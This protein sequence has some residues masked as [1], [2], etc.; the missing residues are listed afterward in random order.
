MKLIASDL[1]GTLLNEKGEISEDNLQAIKKIEGKGIQFVVATGR[2]YDA[3]NKPFQS[4]GLSCPFI[5]LNGANTFDVN[6]Q[7]IHEVTMEFPVCQK[8]IS[9][10]QKAD[11]Y[12]EVFTNYGIYSLSRE[13]FMEVI[14]HVLQTAHADSK[15]EDIQQLIEQRFQDENVQFIN[16]FEELLSSQDIKVYKILSF[17]NQQGELNEAYEKLKDEP[18][19]VITSS[20][21]LNL[22][23]NHPKAQKGTAL[24]DLA[25]KLGIQMKDVMALGDNLNDKSMLLQAGRGVA[26]GNA[27]EEIKELCTYT[28]KTNND[29]GFAFAI[30]EMLK[31]YNL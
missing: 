20:G 16:H 5:C 17:A 4:T 27:A 7:L 12:I 23:F 24:K 26:M 25:N 1:D 13:N 31:E 6:G 14:T 8:I 21:P 3:A 28:T 19:T 9:V 30:N 11:M 29:N 2:S 15:K 10:C 22:E 18:G